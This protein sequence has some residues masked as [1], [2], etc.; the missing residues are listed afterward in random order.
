MK[1][2]LVT[3]SGGRSSAMMA[4]HIQTHPKYKDYNKLYVFANTGMERPET[5]EF[6]KNMVKYWNLPLVLIEGVYSTK[7]G[8]GVRHKIID[9]DTLSMKNEPY[10]GAISQLNKNKWTRLPN[11]GTPYCQTY[12]KERPC[13]SL[14]KEIFQTTDYI[15]AIGYRKED[16]PKRI[17][18]KEI[19]LSKDKIAPL[20]TDFKTPISKFDLTRWYDNQPFKLDLH[21]DL[22][23][24]TL[25][26]KKG[27]KN[28]V[29]SIQLNDRVTQD[30]EWF[31]K[32][33]DK[34][35]NTMF[36]G[37]RSI[38][39]IVKIAENT[40]EQTYLFNDNEGCLCSY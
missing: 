35:G 18:Y 34:Y 38:F 26:W 30:I 36:R 12:L 16:M 2:L 33:E 39:E 1:N 15:K 11:K 25:C 3:V 17:T 32:M 4:R 37:N 21:S 19:E 10:Q 31:K 40:G 20:I 22:G 13:H 7:K 29:K 27:D 6:L 23:N 9:F 8:V 5:I 28:L 14:A 24:C